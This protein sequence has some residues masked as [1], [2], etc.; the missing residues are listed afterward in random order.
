MK[1]SEARLLIYI[2][3]AKDNLCYATYMCAKLEMDYKY[4]LNILAGMLVKAWVGVTKG[5]TGKVYYR[6]VKP[7]VLKEAKE[8]RS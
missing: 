1:D 4:G 8:L 2:D 5:H 3:T 7:D 6:I